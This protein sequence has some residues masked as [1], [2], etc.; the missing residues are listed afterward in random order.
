METFAVTVTGAV[1]AGF[2][3]AETFTA[4][5]AGTGTLE[6]VTGA[7]AAGADDTAFAKA[8]RGFA[9]LAAAATS[10]SAGPLAA[11]AGICVWA[12]KD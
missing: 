10:G 6:I 8:A 5:D 12:A 2:A 1:G 11:G 4:T 3:G 9:G 7:G